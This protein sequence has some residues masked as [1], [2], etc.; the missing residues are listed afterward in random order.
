MASSIFLQ[1]LIKEQIN[2]SKNKSRSKFT[3]LLNQILSEDQ[4]VRGS[5]SVPP[6][7]GPQ[8]PP[9]T[10]LGNPPPPMSIAPAP[11]KSALPP[12]H[13]EVLIT[14]A[15]LAVA[16]LSTNANKLVDKHPELRAP[17]N[18]ISD[19]KD[20]GI[21]SKEEGFSIIKKILPFVKHKLPNGFTLDDEIIQTIKSEDFI[22]KINVIVNSL[23]FNQDDKE[24]NSTMAEPIADLEGKAGDLSV[25]KKSGDLNQAAEEAMEIFKDINPIITS[26][27]ASLTI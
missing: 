6:A 19:V 13:P 23:L 25:Y 9:I 7:I 11:E 1:T 22:D 14:L 20:D 4:T 3:T 27:S 18:D 12:E 10:P 21:L 24:G 16:A 2:L 17:Y 8:T 15:Q 5:M 26:A